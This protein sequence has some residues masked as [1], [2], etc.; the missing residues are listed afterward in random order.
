MASGAMYLPGAG[1]AV[2]ELVAGGAAT[3]ADDL[4]A[5]G[6]SSEN[7]RRVRRMSEAKDV[8]L[9]IAEQYRAWGN[10]RGDGQSSEVAGRDAARRRGGR[11]RGFEA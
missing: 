8:G 2:T 5:A 1:E 10:M 4:Q 6:V 3:G 7:A 11:R 9:D